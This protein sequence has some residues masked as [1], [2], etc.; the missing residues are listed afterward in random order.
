MGQTVPNSSF[1]G[2]RSEV[3]RQTG[4]IAEEP[5]RE[6]PEDPSELSDNCHARGGH[7]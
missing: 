4:A 2:E 5:V 1:K 7:K 3:G 6:I